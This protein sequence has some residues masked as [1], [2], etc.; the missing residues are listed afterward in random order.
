MRRIINSTFITVDGVTEQLEKWHF[1]DHGEQAFDYAIE[2][3]QGCDALLLGRKTYEIYA[4]VW[5]TRDDKWAERANNI[6][7]YVASSTL[8]TGSWDNTTI[9]SGDLVEEITAIKAQPGQDI[10]MNGYGPVARTLVEHGLLDVLELWIH[11]VL[12]GGGSPNELLFH[13][14]TGAKLSLAGTRTLD[15]GVVILTYD[16]VN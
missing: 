10:L 3:I 4:A 6:N 1:D 15:S 16:V 12:F 14:G 2:R 7:K 9:L 5:P 11:P 8:T 13:E